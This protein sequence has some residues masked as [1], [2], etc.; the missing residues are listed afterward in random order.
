MEEITGKAIVCLKCG[1]S[2]SGRRPG[3]ASGRNHLPGAAMR[4]LLP[5]AQFSW[6]NR[7]SYRP[8]CIVRATSTGSAPPPC[9]MATGARARPTSSA[10]PF[11]AAGFCFVA[12]HP[13]GLRADRAGR[14]SITSS[15]AAIFPMAAAFIRRRD[16]RVACSRSVGR[17]AAAGR[18]HGDG[19]AQRLV[20]LE[21]HHVRR[22]TG[23]LDQGA[24]RSHRADHDRGADLH[25]WLNFFG[26]KH[27]GSLAVVLAVPTAIVVVVSDRESARRI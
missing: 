9:S 4:R 26:P 12:D 5:L 19:G 25:G 11:V 23:R 7:S 20:G 3:C 27:S 24:A 16:H 22:G 13:R 6:L 14:D 21:L 2:W 15:S 10:S 18:S 17:A 8:A 1:Q